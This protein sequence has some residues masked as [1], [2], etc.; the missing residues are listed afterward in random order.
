M[1]NQKD[2]QS[3]I[4]AE[5]LLVIFS[6][7]ISGLKQQPFP[8]DQP[9]IKWVYLGTDPLARLKIADSLGKGF[10]L[11]DIARRHRGIADESRKEYVTWHDDLNRYYKDDLSWW[12]GAVSSRNIRQSNIFHY[13]CFLETLKQL[14]AD[15]LQR[16]YLVVVESE[17]L[18]ESIRRWALSQGISVRILGG[19]K[20]IIRR[21]WRYGYAVLRWGKFWG[22]ALLRAWAVLLMRFQG[23]PPLNDQN[24]DCLV[25]TTVHDR[26]LL[27]SGEFSDRYFSILHSYLEQQGAK[28]LVCPFFYGFGYNYSSI[29]QRSRKS[30]TRFVLPE[31]LLSFWDYWDILKYPLCV[32]RRS[33][34]AGSFQGFDLDPIIREEMCEQDTVLGLEPF[35]IYKAYLRMA[36]RFPSLKKAIVWYE[37][38]VIDRAVVMGLRHAFPLMKVIGVQMYLHP[39]YFMSLSPSASEFEAGV[40]PHL[41]LTTSEHENQMAQAFTADVKCQPAAALRYQHLFKEEGEIATKHVRDELKRVL[42]LLPY[43]IGEAVEILGI[44]ADT[45]PGLD[46]DLRFLI[47]AH[48][49]YSIEQIKESLRPPW[50]ACFDD[51]EGNLAQGVAQSDMVISGMS[52]AM[53]EAAVKG[54]PVIFVGGQTSLEENIMADLDLEITVN[55]FTAEE[56]T[57]A[58]KRYSSLTAKQRETFRRTGRE[59][60]DIYF[61]P[62]NENTLIP[63]AG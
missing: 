29:Y 8:S 14:W 26:S 43:D 34:K 30:K 62:V 24:D 12:F 44:I 45:L 21:L 3:A 1:P 6:D 46:K 31:D 52:S 13:Y 59:L 7:I 48:P 51:F 32:L 25:V 60:R 17:A 15:P 38:R 9:S 10:E 50:P 55:C 27:S 4:F 2:R 5:G 19:W 36:R 47:K 16:P 41:I 54:S 28:V 33:T 11:I 40:T 18:A 63:Y 20:V 23:L 49:D 37:N 56:L 58:I 42:V 53:V 35:L 39:R 57:Q 61:L 22:V